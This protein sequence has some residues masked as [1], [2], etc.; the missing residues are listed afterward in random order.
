MKEICE[1]PWNK[2]ETFYTAAKHLQEIGVL[3]KDEKT[4]VLSIKARK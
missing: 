2:V 1:R 3:E 4:K